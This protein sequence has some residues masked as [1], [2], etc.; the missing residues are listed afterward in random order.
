[1][2]RKPYKA[3]GWENIVVI[4]AD[5]N[6][7]CAC[8]GATLAEAKANAALIASAPKMLDT[9]KQYI[10]WLDLQEGYSATLQQ[11]KIEEAILEA[12]NV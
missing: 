6:T 11:K 3:E 12:T 5:G 1:M 7:W 2:S 8:P 4:D 10:D 9:L